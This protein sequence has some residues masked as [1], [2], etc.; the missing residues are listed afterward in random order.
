M[1]HEHP[2]RRH[3]TGRRSCSRA[4]ASTTPTDASTAAEEAGAWAAWQQAAAD[5]EPRGGHRLVGDAGLRGR[6]GA[7]Y[8]DRR[9]VARR[10]RRATPTAL[11]RRQRLRG[12]PRRPGRPH[13][14]GDAT[15]TRSSRASPSP[16]A[17]SAPRGVSSPSRANPPS[18]CG[19]CAPRSRRPRS[20]GYLGADALRRRLRHPRRGARAHRRPRR[21]RG[22]RRC[23]ARSRTSAPSPTSG[24]RIPAREGLWGRADASSTTSRRSP[25]CPGS[26]P[27]ARRAFAAHRRPGSAGHDARPAQRR[28]QQAGH[29]RGAAGHVAARDARRRRGGSSGTL[30]AVLVGGPT[31]GFLPPAELDTPLHAGGADAR[32]ARSW[33]RARSSSSTTPTCLV[34]MATLLTRYLTDE[35][36]GKTI[37]C[38]I[39]TAPAGRAR[40]ARDRAACPPD[41][42]RSSLEDLAADIRD[43]ALCGL[44]RTARPTRS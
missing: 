1:S 32:R 25:P 28:G 4:P 31:G 39:G 33:A 11:R 16:P 8:P 43:G 34:D 29:R 35:A 19:G 21:R 38:R 36:C 3:G 37:P 41:R 26:S 44:E 13:A 18:R 40:P 17:R 15:R 12:R 24:R 9:Q 10:G 2:A 7:G 20:A 22:D 30:K 42:R 6:G 27:T 23:C 5:L 14:H